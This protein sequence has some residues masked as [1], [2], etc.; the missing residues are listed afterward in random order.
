MHVSKFGEGEEKEENEAQDPRG[1]FQWGTHVERGWTQDP[2][3]TEKKN[4]A[5]ERHG[6]LRTEMLSFLVFLSV[7]SFFPELI[8]GVRRRY[9][10]VCGFDPLSCASHIRQGGW[11]TYMGIVAFGSLPLELFYFGYLR[12]A[13]QRFCCVFCLVES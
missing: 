13:A 6:T 3:C 1:G 8:V 7:L 11:V 12:L 9:F 4:V 5:D 10:C 2:T